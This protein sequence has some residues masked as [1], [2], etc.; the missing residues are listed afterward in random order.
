MASDIDIIAR[1]ILKTRERLN[2]LY[3]HH[4]GQALEAIE[5]VMDRCVG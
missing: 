1:E 2:Q 4:T 5:R 3:M